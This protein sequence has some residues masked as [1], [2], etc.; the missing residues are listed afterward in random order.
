MGSKC[1]ICGS[2]KTKLHRHHIIKR[3]FGGTDAPYN[4]AILCSTCHRLVDLERIGHV[5]QAHLKTIG[6]TEKGF[7]IE[8]KA[9]KNQAITGIFT[10]IS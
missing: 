9:L 2:T 1:V 4:I 10:D 3:R 8:I 6:M 7:C 5:G